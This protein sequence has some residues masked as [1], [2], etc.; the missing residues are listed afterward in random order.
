MRT[1]L[2]F[3]FA[4]LIF[5]CKGPQGDPGPAGE[6]G[7]KGDPGAAGAT[8][9]QGPS[10]NANVMQLTFGSRTHTGAELSYALTGVTSAV[11]NQSAYFTYVS[12]NNNFWYSLPG[13]TVGGS[14]EYRT[15]VSK[16]AATLY[17]NR[18]SGS[19]SEV[20]SQTRIVVIPAS[21][22][23]N[24]RLKADLDFNDYHAVARYFNLEE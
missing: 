19:G 12:P 24:A 22:L 16:T 18:V 11:L 13:T 5:S 10:G 17:I 7:P 14:R 6:Q 1:S 2:F 23:T 4:L 8:G 3:A 20:F 21:V 9:P 15:F